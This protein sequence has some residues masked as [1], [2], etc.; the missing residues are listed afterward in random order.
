MTHEPLNGSTGNS[1]NV[2]ETLALIRRMATQAVAQTPTARD[3]SAWRI[4][5][6]MYTVAQMVNDL[7]L[8]WH[9]INDDLER[10]V[11]A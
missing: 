5:Q 7:D 2:D 9:V 10:Y 4:Q 6:A 8:A 1:P 3:P 11:E